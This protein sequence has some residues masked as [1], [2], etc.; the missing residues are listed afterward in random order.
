MEVKP[1]SHVVTTDLDADDMAVS[2]TYS[3]SRQQY[4]NDV[5]HT[6][7]GWPSTLTD[8]HEERP[9]CGDENRSDL[10]SYFDFM[11]SQP[12]PNGAAHST[13]GGLPTLADSND[14]E[15][16]CGDERQSD[17][18]S[19]FDFMVSSDLSPDAAEIVL[20][21]DST[22]DGHTQTFCSGDGVDTNDLPFHK[23]SGC[24]N[25]N[26]VDTVEEDCGRA[27]GGTSDVL[28]DEDAVHIEED[29]QGAMVL[30]EMSVPEHGDVAGGIEYAASELHHDDGTCVSTVTEDRRD[31]I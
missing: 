20:S 16:S 31:I 21:T 19:Y 17:L 5:A 2:S 25:I 24:L 14:D 11:V 12:H 29:R 28:L 22:K 13:H 9:F 27:Q 6:H 1:Y 30:L 26:D 4:P 23:G 10:R 15:G 8:A 3:S 7:E 18:Q